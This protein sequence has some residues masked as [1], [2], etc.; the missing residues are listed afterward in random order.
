MLLRRSTQSLPFPRKYPKAVTIPRQTHFNQQ[1]PKMFDLHQRKKSSLLVLC[2]VLAAGLLSGCRTIPAPEPEAIPPRLPST[3]NILDD[4][5][6]QQ[7]L[8]LTFVKAYPG[9]ISDVRFLDND[10]TMLVNGV[11]F[12]FAQGRFL[13]EDLRHQWEAFY[14][15][16]FYVYPWVGTIEERRAAFA[17]PVRSVG[18][19][20]LFD[21]LWA[22]PTEADSW[23]QQV[24]YSFLGVRMLVHHYIAPL[25]DRV[26]ERILAE[27]ETDPSINEWIAELQ[28]GPP[29]GGWNWRYIAGTNRRSLHSYGI[30]IDLLPRDL[31]GRHTYWQW[32]LDALDMDNLY[33]PPQAVVRA[34]EAYGFLWG[35]NWN[36]ID[37]M[38][39]EYRPEVFILSGIEMEIQR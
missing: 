31:R 28:P 6:A 18:S 8:M 4:L 13:P 39:F 21:T 15:Y 23:L 14:P 30:A 9:K 24:T 37:T 25:L 12:F 32:S 29:S 2:G 26:Q 10:W 34:F 27:A 17:N 33:A 5:E 20:F 16:D 35:G 7:R 36:I 1:E 19:P 38:H 11:R 3:L 22:S